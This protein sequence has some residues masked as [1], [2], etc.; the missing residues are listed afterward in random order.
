MQ[1]AGSFQE[2]KEFSGFLK[3]FQEFWIKTFED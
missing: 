3:N 2:L 1:V